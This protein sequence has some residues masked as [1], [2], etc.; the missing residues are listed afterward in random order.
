MRWFQ[1]R[2]LRALICWANRPPKTGCFRAQ[3]LQ[4]GRQEAIHVLED[5]VQHHKE[6]DEADDG[7]NDSVAE[8]LG[9]LPS[10]QHDEQFKK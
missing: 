6:W 1:G 9:N 2:L 10:T 8:F 4:V 5:E 3:Q 7:S